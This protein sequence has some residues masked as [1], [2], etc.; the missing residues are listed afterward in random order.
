MKTRMVIGLVMTLVLG[1]LMAAPVS[2]EPGK[3]QGQ[4]QGQGAQVSRGTQADTENPCVD[5]VSA[6]V[7]LD[8]VDAVSQYKWRWVYKSNGRPSKLFCRIKGADIDEQMVDPPDK[9]RG[10]VVRLRGTEDLAGICPQ[11]A[12]I[13]SPVGD[14][15]RARF[16]LNAKGNGFLKCVYEPSTN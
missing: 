12:D 15:F 1:A 4:G 5:A 14:L 7:D 11:P 8:E 13:D 3:G 2:A 6:I 16:K 9:P 10:N